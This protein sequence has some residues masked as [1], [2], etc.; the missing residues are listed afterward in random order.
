MTSDGARTEVCDR[1]EGDAEPEGALPMAQ[2]RR[3]E[4]QNP[5]LCES[6]RDEFVDWVQAGSDRKEIDEVYEDRNLLACALATATKA[7]SGWKKDPENSD[8]WAIV[9]IE[10]P[11]GQL[12]W[13]VPIEMAADLAP[14]RKP[15]EYDGYDRTEKND[16][17]ASWT[18]RGC[19]C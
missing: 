4:G 17:L 6:C 5:T 1:C 10:T 19:V 2:Y 9:W 11:I 13:H 7:P 15:A 16:R 3:S 8:D 14:P 18:L 12:S